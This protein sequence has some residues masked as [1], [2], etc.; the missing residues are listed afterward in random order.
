MN[1]YVLH[2]AGD[3]RY[4]QLLAR[5]GRMWRKAVGK[6]RPLRVLTTPATP[7][8]DGWDCTLADPRPYL[9]R[10]YRPGH[11]GAAFDYKM[12]VIMALFDRVQG[13]PCCILDSDNLIYRD[14]T[15]LLDTL[16]PACLHL[17]LDGGMRSITHPA[18]AV[19]MLEL[20]TSIAIWPADSRALTAKY[21]HLW[22]TSTEPGHELLEQ[23]TTSLVFHTQQTPAA[24]QL[25]RTYAWSRFWGP[26]PPDC[27]IKHPHGAEK[28][29]GLN[30]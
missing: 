7:S 12:C 19:P 10:Y 18:F 9:A 29:Q 17:G 25:P 15:P 8:W 11:P 14:P 21:R 26:T 24:Q 23:R 22:A 4:N 16:D 27:I 2:F 6:T 1:Y 30:L 20:T 3:P 13:A 28:W 5:I